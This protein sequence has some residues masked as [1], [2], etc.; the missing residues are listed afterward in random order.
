MFAICTSVSQLNTKE[1]CVICFPNDICT[2]YCI[3]QFLW[4]DPES[5]LHKGGF[6]HNHLLLADVFYVKNIY[7][8]NQ[9]L[10]I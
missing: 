1:H 3:L 4:K 5:E 10:K 8:Y 6:P 2:V 9:F 7:F